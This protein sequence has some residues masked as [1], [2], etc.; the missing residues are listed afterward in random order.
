MVR[1]KAFLP[2]TSLLTMSD[3]DFRDPRDNGLNANTAQSWAFVHYLLHSK[4]MKK[5]GKKLLVKYFMVIQEG[6]AREVAFAQTFGSVDLRKL[7]VSFKNAGWD[8][9]PLDVIDKD[10]VH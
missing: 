5:K 2:L 3:D 4:D 6:G 8:C 9:C 1:D 7:D 10:V